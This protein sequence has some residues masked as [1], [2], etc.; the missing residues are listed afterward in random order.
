MLAL[1]PSV[2]T[3][4]LPGIQLAAR[5]GRKGLFENRSPDMLLFSLLRVTLRQ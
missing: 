5:G 3:G 2:C 1:L 4:D